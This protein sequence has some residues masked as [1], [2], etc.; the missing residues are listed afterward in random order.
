[1]KT[2]I[3]YSYANI[4]KICLQTYSCT[5]I[6]YLQKTDYQQV[7]SFSS[8]FIVLFMYLIEIFLLVILTG[9]IILCQHLKII[10]KFLS[11][12]IFK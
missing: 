12:T 3:T 7:L 10:K 9:K 1:M 11:L 8:N 2:K 4:H 5:S 6:M